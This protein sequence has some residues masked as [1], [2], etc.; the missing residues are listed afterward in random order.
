MA[1]NFHMPLSVDK[2]RKEGK[3]SINLFS[4]NLIK[5]GSL[6]IQEPHSHMFSLNVIVWRI[7][8]SWSKPTF[9]TVAVMLPKILPSTKSYSLIDSETDMI[10]H[11]K[12]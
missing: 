3:K 6:V 11:F 8:V 7:H 4:Y 10:V 9:I 5:A 12:F 2:D 1:L